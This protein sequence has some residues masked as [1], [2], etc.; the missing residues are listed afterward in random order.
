[1]KVLILSSR[2]RIILKYSYLSTVVI[3]ENHIK[4]AVARVHLIPWSLERSTEKVQALSGSLPAH[5][6]RSFDRCLLHW[7]PPCS[8]LGR[9]FGR[10]YSTYSSRTLLVPF[11]GSVIFSAIGRCGHRQIST[12]TQLQAHPSGLLHWSR[13]S[14]SRAA[15]GSSLTGAILKTRSAGGVSGSF[16]RSVLKPKL[17]VA[18][19]LSFVSSPTLLHKFQVIYKFPIFAQ[20]DVFLSMPSEAPETID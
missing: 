1:M 18:G 9:F 6:S 5:S 7:S 10:L 8:A 2:A 11:S 12:V 4:N 19:L 15:G 16:G 17:L 3:F 14:S 20:H 13:G